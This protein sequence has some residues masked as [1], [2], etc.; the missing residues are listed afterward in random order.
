MASFLLFV[1]AIAICDCTAAG[2]ITSESEL[3]FSRV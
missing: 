3:R 1:D 2:T